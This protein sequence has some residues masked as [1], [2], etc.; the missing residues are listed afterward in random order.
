M[1]LPHIVSSLHSGNKFHLVI[2]CAVLFRSFKLSV[3]FF[4]GGQYFSGIYIS[5]KNLDFFFLQNFSLERKGEK[6]T[7][8][9]IYWMLSQKRK[10]NIEEILSKYLSKYLSKLN[11]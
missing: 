2:R 11:I 4:L 8:K 5:K 9:R 7:E 6:F 1:R 3:F 10:L